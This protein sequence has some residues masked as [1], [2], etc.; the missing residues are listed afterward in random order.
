VRISGAVA[1]VTGASSGI[2]A[3]TVAEL[4]QR[5]ARVVAVAR[6]ESRLREV[7]EPLG[8]AASY[9]V[10]DVASDIAVAAA[11]ARVLAD[12]GHID[13]LVN[14]AGTPLH[15]AFRE[16]DLADVMRVMDV[17]YLGAVRWMQAVLP[18][19]AGRGRGSIVNVASTAGA[20][21]WTWEA[22]YSAS[23][24]AVIALTEAAAPELA[25]AGVHC[26]WVNPGLVRTEIFSDEALRHVPPRV[27]RSFMEPEVVARAI[28][29]LVEREG[30]GVSVPR[31]MGFPPVVR[32]LLPR[33]YRIGLRRTYEATLRRDAAEGRVP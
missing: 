33:L 24:A 1:V 14:N 22:A 31:G 4:A 32:Q 3:A 6:R 9:L 18:A 7:V 15:R 20:A 16:T 17:N 19:M 5:G 29:A 11:A 25:R 2:G 10:C 26:A 12:H 30:A 8:A 21:P 28:C 13:L 27:R 23:K